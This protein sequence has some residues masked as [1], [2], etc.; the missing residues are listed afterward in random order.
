MTDLDLFHTINA[1]SAEEERL[2]ASASDGSGLSQD[3]QDRLDQI[4]V[5]LDRVY[6]LLHQRQARAA[7]RAGPRRGRGAV[8]GG[9]RALPADSGFITTLPRQVEAS[10]GRAR[11][12][13][14]TFAMSVGH[15]E[16]RE[17]SSF[18]SATYL[19]GVRGCV[20]SRAPCTW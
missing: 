12:N 5:E 8:R 7:G 1:L 6:D 17:A 14:W 11:R 9:G 16:R 20:R 10:R 18:G 2:Y 4:K 19:E 13:G 3:E 15:P